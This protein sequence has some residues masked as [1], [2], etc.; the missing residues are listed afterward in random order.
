MV[1]GF[2]EK[3][4]GKIWVESEEG[5]GTAMIFTLPFAK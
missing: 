4:G 5:K 1:K 3:N 2:V